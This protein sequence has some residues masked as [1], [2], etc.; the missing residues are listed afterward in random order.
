MKL[1]YYGKPYA[2][3]NKET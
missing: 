1:K 3:W 2:I